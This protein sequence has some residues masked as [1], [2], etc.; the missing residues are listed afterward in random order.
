MYGALFEAQRVQLWWK[1]LFAEENL[2]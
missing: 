2:N 1:A